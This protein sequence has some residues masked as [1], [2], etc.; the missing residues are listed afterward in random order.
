MPET[1]PSI[2][3]FAQSLRTH[4]LAAMSGGF[5]VPFTAAAVF[6]G[7]KYQQAIFGCL[8]LTALWFAAYR[9]WKVE[10]YR[11]IELQKKL[12]G[13]KLTIQKVT[14]EK[15]PHEDIGD[16]FFVIRN[17]GELPTTIHNWSLSVIRPDGTNIPHLHARILPF[18]RRIPSQ[19]G[20]ALVIV[21]NFE[22][23]P[24]PVGARREA[25][26]AFV[27]NGVNVEAELGIKGTK[28]TL[29]CEDGNKM[30]YQAEY[31]MP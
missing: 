25:R 30:K 11:V 2:W 13:V 8:A 24:I 1:K 28:F 22:N 10:R 6:A 26:Y 5:S 19:D 7:D 18:P 29:S 23:D 4:W 20:R 9:V 17:G 31:E 16:V 12:E 15:P 14:F 27:H 3:G 21:D